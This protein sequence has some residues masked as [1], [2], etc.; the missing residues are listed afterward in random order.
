M[1]RAWARLMKTQQ[2]LLEQ[3]DVKLKQ[4]NL[5]PLA[6]YDVLLE[7][8]RRG[9]AGLRPSELQHEMLLAQYNLS[10]LLDRIELA[11]HI[12]R[13]R[14]EHDGRGQVVVITR[15]GE[16]LVR[17]M[18]PVYARFL[19]DSIG[20][21]LSDKEARSLAEVLGKLLAAHTA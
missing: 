6:W 15:S 9:T 8:K 20:A 11:G 10:R 7:L 18:W 5:P 14:C 13:R 3:I 17:R 1:V 2:V 12:V 16:T 4:A 21:P 19:R